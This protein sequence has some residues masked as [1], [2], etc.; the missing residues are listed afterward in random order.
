MTPSLIFLVQAL[1]IVALPV[2]LL[3]CSGLKGLVPL[4]VVQ[5]LLGIALGPSAFGRV[6]P[7]F[8]R[9]L[10]NP[11][12][13]SYLSG[14]SSVAVLI[15]GLITGL[16]LDPEAFRGSGRSFTTMAAARLVVPVALGCM[17]GLWIL[18]RHPEELLPGTSP[19]EFAAAVGICSGMTALPVLGTILR[20]MNLLGKRFGNL[21]LGIAGINDAAL[22]VLLSVLLTAAAGRGADRGPGALFSLLLVPVYLL[23]MARVVRPLLG[24]MVVSRMRDEAV[25]ERSMAVVGAV[26]I[27][28]AL[29]TEA[30]GLHYIIGAFVTGIVMPLNLRKP[31]LDRLQVMTGALLM[32]F[33]FT[34]TGLRTMIDLGSPA[35]LEIFGV[36]TAVAVIGTTVGTA[37][38]AR[39]V[40]ESW[41]FSLGLGALLQTKGLMEVIVLTILLDAGI[42]SANIF[43]ALILMAVVSTALAMP[44]TQL[45]LAQDNKRQKSLPPPKDVQPSASCRVPCTAENHLV[46]SKIRPEIAVGQAPTDNVGRSTSTEG[47]RTERTTVS[48]AASQECTISGPKAT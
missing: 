30:M 36:T 4:V 16:H 19:V 40:G 35:F 14:V 43:A 6:A 37:A 38:A 5:I 12:S 29:A 11:T 21:A 33:F 32:P 7:D 34:L 46:V 25:H 18:G 15:F 13:L 8:Y 45:M 22:W 10:S 26:T 2:V 24:S 44:L 48:P 42:I 39:S 23:V 9:I 31:I 27:A 41:P 20:D 17:T 28:S 1:A 47:N 3:R